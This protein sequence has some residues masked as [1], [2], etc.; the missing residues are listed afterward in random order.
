MEII[1][2]Y[3]SYIF[4]ILFVSL[5]AHV[6]AN[7]NKKRHLRNAE[8]ID[9]SR[10]SLPFNDGWE[11][12]FADSVLPNTE[13][14]LLVLPHTWSSAESI[15]AKT[16]YYRT[17]AVYQ[18]K[19][20]IEK[21]WKNKRLFI[22]FEGVNSVA[23][24][25]INQKFVGE[26]RGGYTA[27]CFEITNFIKADTSNLITVN[28]SNSYRLDVLPLSGDFNIYGG[29]H[30]PV[31]IIATNKNCITPLDYG[32]PGVF[33]KQKDVSNKS[34]TIE[35]LV[36]LSLRNNSKSLSL[37]TIFLNADDKAVIK[38]VVAIGKG[39][40]S[41][42]KYNY[43]IT[44]P[45]LWNGKKDP[46]LYHVTVQLLENDE[47]IDEVTQ[48]LG[49]RFFRVDPDK[50][51]FLNGKHLDLH[52]FG[53]H[54]DVEGKGSAVSRQE[55]ERDIELI[56]ESGA[57]AMRL[58]HYPHSKDFYNLS[59]SNGIILWT[60]IP[61]VGPGGYTGPGYIH[62]ALLE[63]NGKQILTELIRQNY[64]HP[65]ICFWGLFN[66]LKLDYDDPLPYVK[67]L[68]ALAHK[69]DPTRL[70]TCAT[71]IDSNV[72]NHASDVIAWNKYFGWYGS[73]PKQLGIWADDVH[74]KFPDKP[75]AISEYGAGASTKQHTEVLKAPAAKGRFHPEEW[76]TYLHE[77]SWRQLNER[78]F[79]WGKFVWV[80]ADFGSSIR[81]EGDT[82]GM[83]D[84]GLTTYDRKIKKDAFYFY[85]ANWNEEPMISIAERRNDK[86][87]LNTTNI[88]AFTNLPQAELFVN[89]KSLGTKTKDSI[90]EVVWE[91]ISLKKGKNVIRVRAN[92]GDKTLEDTCEWEL[93]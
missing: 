83:N 73:V 62:N 5:A 54:Q 40:D 15:A 85:K 10:Q 67:E 68:N 1:K 91:N 71:F 66:E 13:K 50:G 44:N 63:Q 36:Q 58:T 90:N 45:H 34:A 19:F 41:T 78:P 53:R 79:I 89:G 82:N 47:V 3:Y 52:G 60:E 11:F 75:I 6:N 42:F 8:A 43:T 49:L 81:T 20:T 65:A 2:K 29:I 48:P 38:K 12:H 30:R 64:N 70:T 76:Q 33:L 87:T 35:A 74:K 21:G 56:K 4:I 88:K 72:F 16:N 55:H 77:E 25:F 93:E 37:K 7:G 61:L 86:R 32:S 59:D 46:Y 39:S 92:D 69:E 31:S 18:K 9:I 57:T 24:I 84:K 14:N 28:V 51:F 26:H 80:L 22:Y 17:A 23:D 27:F